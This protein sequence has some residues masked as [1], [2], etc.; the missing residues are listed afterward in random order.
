MAQLTISQDTKDQVFLEQLKLE[1]SNP[2]QRRLQDAY[3]GQTP[4]QLMEAELTKI[5]LEVLQHED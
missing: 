3:N 4:V 5:L 1:T 2:L